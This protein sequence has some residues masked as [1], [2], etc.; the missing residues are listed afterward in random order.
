MI[1]PCCCYLLAGA[2]SVCRYDLDRRILGVDIYVRIGRYCV[3][4]RRVTSA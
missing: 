4:R 3:K 2:V 1:C